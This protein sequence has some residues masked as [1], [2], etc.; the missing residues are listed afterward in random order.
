MDGLRPESAGLVLESAVTELVEGEPSAWSEGAAGA[1][2][3]DLFGEL[4]GV[5][6]HSE[7][8]V[9]ETGGG[10]E[11]GN[12]Q[13]L[14]ELDE[15]EGAAGP[16]ALSAGAALESSGFVEVS[17]EPVL[18]ALGVCEGMSDSMVI[19]E[20]PSAGP[21]S[22][23]SLVE[24]FL[25]GSLLSA[26][27][28]PSGQASGRDQVDVFRSPTATSRDVNGRAGLMGGGGAIDL[29][30]TSDTV[31]ESGD[32]LFKNLSIVNGATLSVGGGSTITVEGAF[33]IAGNSTLLCRGKNTE[34]QVD[35]VW[36]GVGVTINA[37]NVTV[38]SGSKISA[39][40]QGYAGAAIVPAAGLGPGGGSGGDWAGGGSHGG[41][42]GSR[43]GPAYGSTLA[44]VALGSGGGTWDGLDWGGNG[45]GAIRLD[46]SGTLTLDGVISANGND[47]GEDGG[48]GAGG[49]IWVTVGELK[50]G[51]RFEARGGNGIRMTYAGGGGGGRIAVQYQ[52]DGGF[53][54][55]GSSTVAGGAG[56]NPG[57]AGTVVFLDGSVPGGKL[58]VRGGL[59]IR[60]DEVVHLGM[61][62]VP[63]GAS[64]TLGGGSRLVVDGLLELQGDAAIYCVGKNRGAQVDG[65]WAGAGVTIE[66]GSLVIGSGARITA[67][68]LGYLGGESGSIGS[69][70]RGPGGAGADVY[71]GA[72]GGYGGGGG[73]T[74]GGIAYG[75]VLE[76]LDL[77]SGG[78]DNADNSPGGNGGA[79]GG[80]IHIKVSGTL[81]LEGTIS[82]NGQDGV[83]G[84]Q[85]GGSGGSLW[86]ETE[87]LEGN[88]LVLA[89]G[90]VGQG[91]GGGGGGGRIAIYYRACPMSVSIWRLGE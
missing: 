45:G 26:N 46:V 61:L 56:R 27:G 65:Q 32:Y 78:G 64:V 49:S 16:N 75:S 34:Q 88:G 67:D 28:P 84:E 54:G 6:V 7:S 86:I 10:I 29:I 87:K 43:S 76:P 53:G 59:D 40:G 15:A 72:G 39:D 3:V 19:C 35:G 71:H 9:D 22:S 17:S 79:G 24:T 83:G 12:R 21:V 23:G 5:P 52:T 41:I 4:S 69:S 91:A 8:E 90:G 60:E 44:P 70:G 74:Y 51:G 68:G 18:C 36:A 58:V 11:T 31:W 89:R 33:V 62:V 1:A 55:F 38:E 77:G 66:A 80:A 57:A 85:G 30:V 47:G 2:V 73:T 63:A 25:T 20:T 14:G 82:A 13:A 37:A 81:T 48:G 42:G 50:G